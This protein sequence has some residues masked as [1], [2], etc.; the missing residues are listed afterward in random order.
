M[1]FYGSFLQGI[2]SVELGGFLL[3]IVDICGAFAHEKSKQSRGCVTIMCWKVPPSKQ[4]SAAA[5]SPRQPFLFPPRDF[6]LPGKKCD[7]IVFF[8]RQLLTNF[9]LLLGSFGHKLKSI[10]YYS[11]W[12]LDFKIA[13]F[14][15]WGSVNPI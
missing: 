12:S 5:V 13:K 4:S 10:V 3:C 11:E 6:L 14:K 8:F 15:H 1:I 9:W 2:S 7:Q